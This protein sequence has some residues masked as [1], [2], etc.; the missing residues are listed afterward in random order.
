MRKKYLLG[1]MLLSFFNGVKPFEKIESFE[2]Q[3]DQGVFS[4]TQDSDEI[5][6]FLELTEGDA[7]TENLWSSNFQELIDEIPKTNIVFIA[8]GE[9]AD[10]RLNEIKENVIGTDWEK[11]LHFINKN[12]TVLPGNIESILSE[13]EKEWSADK[14]GFLIDSNGHL[15]QFGLLRPPGKSPTPIFDAVEK[16]IQYL[17]WEKELTKKM[18]LNDKKEEVVMLDGF[19]LSGGWGANAEFEVEFPKT[20]KLLSFNE[21][22]IYFEMNCPDNN[23]K[24]CYEWDMIANLHLCEENKC[25]ILMSR[26]IT[27]YHRRG[28]WLTDITPFLAFFKEGGVKK[29]KINVPTGNSSYIMNMRIY[30]SKNDSKL[31]PM[32]AHRMWTGGSFN[33]EYNPSKKPYLLENPQ[34][35]KYTINGIMSGHGWGRDVANCAEFCNHTHHF[36]INGEILGELKDPKAGT[37][38]GCYQLAN[39]GVVPNQFGTWPYGRAYWCPGWDVL[40]FSIEIKN[41]NRGNM[42]MTYEA[43]YE[44]KPYDPQENPNSNESGFNADINMQSWLVS[45]ENPYRYMLRKNFFSQKEE[46]LKILEGK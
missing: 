9:S 23:D 38:E 13:W 35:E 1:L 12:N 36:S 28:V 33:L 17:Y 25:D 41:P 24:N 40:P 10:Q 8:S 11:Y 30:L 27:T 45:W 44:G 37:G 20:Q 46:S 14:A 2:L 43:L 42:L 32:N 19:E 16:E 26:W 21:M 7:Y 39:E 4:Y 29:F 18:K 15:R 31:R 5:I 6:A 3:V 22:E 34:F